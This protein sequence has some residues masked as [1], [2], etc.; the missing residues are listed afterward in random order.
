MHIPLRK[1]KGDFQGFRLICKDGRTWFGTLQLSGASIDLSRLQGRSAQLAQA[2][3]VLGSTMV[4]VGRLVKA[5][6]MQRTVLTVAPVDFR[7]ERK[8]IRDEGTKR[9]A[10]YA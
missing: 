7:P 6:P 5:R 1:L 10:S 4:L 2:S 3:R 8:R 9:P